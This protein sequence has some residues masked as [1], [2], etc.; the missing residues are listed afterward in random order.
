MNILTFSR[1]VN[2]N[3]RLGICFAAVLAAGTGWWAW[4]SRDNAGRNEVATPAAGVADLSPE[5]ALSVA[6]AVAQRSHNSL[7]GMKALSDLKTALLGMEPRHAAAWITARLASGDDFSTGRDLALG[8]SG[9]LTEWPALRVFLLDTLFIIEPAAAAELGRRILQSPTTADEWALAMRNVGAGSPSTEDVALLKT[10]SAEMLHSETWRK[11][12][13][14]GYLQAFDVIVHT[15]NVALSPELIQSTGDTANK[16]VRHAAFL[17]LDRLTLAEPVAMLEKLIPSAAAQPDTALMV[18]NMVARADVRDPAQRR[19]V[20]DYLLDE[21]RTAAEVQAFTGVFPNASQFVSPNLLTK[22][23][24]IPGAELTARDR[25]ALQVVE[26]WLGD[27]R[28]SRI[29]AS[30]L[31]TRGRLR[32]FVTP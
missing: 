25:G 24:T 4:R 13:S 5:A 19:L 9:S 30:L 8:Q 1:T 27:P 28:F 23:A 3:T 16:A 7:G 6:L 18:S 14:A 21:K 26:A 10:K 11:E 32:S 31:G 20:E 12:A 15:Q 22:V 29:H 17:T 2:N